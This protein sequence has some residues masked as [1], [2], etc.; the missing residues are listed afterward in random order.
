MLPRS[1]GEPERHRAS[2]DQHGHA[3]GAALVEKCKRDRVLR[4]E[5]VYPILYCYR[6]GLEVAIKWI[7]NRYGGYAYIAADGHTPRS[8]AALA[9]RKKVIV[10]L[11]SE[12]ESDALLAVAQIV[13][14]FHE[15]DRGSFSF[16][17]ST[18]KRGAFI[19]LPSGA[20]GLANIQDVMDAANN[21]FSAADGQLIDAHAGA[22]DWGY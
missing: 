1:T 6:R 4:R 17:C 8:L 11:G 19:S 13:K 14:D 9:G 15:L 21:F 5:L 16:R 3:A 18:D 7:I 2:N 10:D 22:A 12:G 20:F